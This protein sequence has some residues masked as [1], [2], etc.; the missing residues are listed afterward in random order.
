MGEFMRIFDFGFFVLIVLL[1]FSGYL[2]SKDPFVPP[3]IGKA[4]TNE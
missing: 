4:H 2:A 3:F 1:T